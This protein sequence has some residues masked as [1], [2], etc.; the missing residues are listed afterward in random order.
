MLGDN[1][2]IATEAVSPWSLVATCNSVEL[3]SVHFDSPTFRACSFILR[4]LSTG[5]FNDQRDRDLCSFE[6]R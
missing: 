1:V 3:F 5:G 4:L 2:L 6:K